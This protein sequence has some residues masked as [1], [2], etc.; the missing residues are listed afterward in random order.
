MVIPDDGDLLIHNCG[1]YMKT[2]ITSLLMISSIPS[3]AITARSYIVMNALSGEVIMQR[4]AFETR[5]IASITKLFIV[6]EA[7]KLNHKEYITITKEDVYNGRMRSTPLKI[8]TSYTREQLT[9]LALVSSDNVAAIALGRFSKPSSHY[10]SLVES[11]G[12][13]PR[14]QSTAFN[15]AE[16]ARQLYLTDIGVISTR[17]ITEIGNRRST[18]PLLS[19]AG[20]NF[21][22][23]KTGYI[24][25]SGGCMVVVLKVKEQPVI[26]TILGSSSVPARWQDLIEIRKLLGDSNFYTITTSN[27]RVKEKGVK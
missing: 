1:H 19:K 5:P 14:N 4:N 6:E 2:L 22:L 12:L 17:M 23:S 20:W 15:L 16:Y 8:G 3:Y 11:S 7:I 10:A 18:N 21:Y 9:E 26:I 25:E 13:N 24:K 27:K